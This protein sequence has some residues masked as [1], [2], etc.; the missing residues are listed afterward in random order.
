[1][2]SLEGMVRSKPVIC[3]L[4][5]DLIDLY[6]NAGLIERGELPHINSTTRDI[7]STLAMILNESRADLREKGAA[8]RRYAEKH[9]SPEYIGKIFDEILK[10]IGITKR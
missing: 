2:F 3:Y 10:H 5:N 1:M 9:H 4:R 6:E 8:S 7:K